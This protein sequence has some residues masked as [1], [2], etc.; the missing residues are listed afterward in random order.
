MRAR[1]S[2][3]ANLVG[4][5]FFILIVV[6]MV[7][8]LIATKFNTFN[9]AIGGPAHLGQSTLAAQQQQISRPEPRLRGADEL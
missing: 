5:V 7:G 6:L 9:S 3:I 1:R 8:A 2:G 4:A